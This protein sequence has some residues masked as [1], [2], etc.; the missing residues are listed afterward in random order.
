MN[1][2]VTSGPA[3]IV[4]TR[5]RD[6]ERMSLID[7][8]VAESDDEGV[9]DPQKVFETIVTDLEML[10]ADCP[11]APSWELVD[12]HAALL[13][14]ELGGR[15]TEIQTAR[16]SLRRRAMLERRVVRAARRLVQGGSSHA[17][18]NELRARATESI[19]GL[20]HLIDPDLRVLAS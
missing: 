4:F 15:V 12:L 10:T 7:F 14:F 19:E 5:V 1:S 11:T 17:S 3:H 20:I 13:V 8:P 9:L 16:A 2:G 6:D 18:E